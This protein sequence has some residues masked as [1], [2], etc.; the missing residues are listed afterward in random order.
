MVDDVL[1]T[2]L[3]GGGGVY[4]IGPLGL[5]PLNDG[6]RRIEDSLVRSG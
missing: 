3:L 2:T 1:K 5:E 6:R 4:S